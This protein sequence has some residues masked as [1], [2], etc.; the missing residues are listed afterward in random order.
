MCENGR[1]ESTVSFDLMSPKPY[2]NEA[3][4]FDVMLLCESITP[5]GL[6]VVPDV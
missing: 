5:F 6:P 3:A 1:I 2:P 4:T